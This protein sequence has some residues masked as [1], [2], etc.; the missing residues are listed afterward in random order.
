[1]S[2]VY[3][4]VGGLRAASGGF[5]AGLRGTLHLGNRLHFLGIGFLNGSN[6][7]GAMFSVAWLMAAVIAVSALKLDSD[8]ARHGALA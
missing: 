3:Q 8:L 7:R 1:M 2:G 5:M 4:H 6:P